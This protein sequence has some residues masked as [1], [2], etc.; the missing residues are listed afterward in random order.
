MNTQF[1]TRTKAATGHHPCMLERRATTP[2]SQT[3]GIAVASYLCTEKRETVALRHYPRGHKEGW[4]G[5]IN[6]SEL[7]AD[8]EDRK[9][10]PEWYVI[11]VSAA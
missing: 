7:Y 5:Y 3:G 2:G 8:H 1:E 4:G 9:L 11:L 6:E 10:G